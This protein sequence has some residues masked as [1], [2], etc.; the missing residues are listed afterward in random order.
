MGAWVRLSLRRMDYEYPLGTCCLR[1]LSSTPR[2]MHSNVHGFS[3]DFRSQ[4]FARLPAAF[5]GTPDV[6]E[7]QHREHLSFAM[8][9]CNWCEAQGFASAWARAIKRPSGMRLSMVTSS[10]VKMG[11]SAI[12]RVL[13]KHRDHLPDVAQSRVAKLAMMRRA[14][15]R[16][17]PAL[18]K[19]LVEGG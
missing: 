7:R 5:G 4:C 3:E 9:E 2:D 14:G 8:S 19:P 16:S 18:Q 17:S 10:E 15:S 12:R 13:R 1:S 11:F 6:R